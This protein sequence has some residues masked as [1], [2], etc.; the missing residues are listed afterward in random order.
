M[1]QLDLAILG[2]DQHHDTS[3]EMGTEIDHDKGGAILQK[4]RDPIPPLEAP[5]QESRGKLFDLSSQL[6]I[7]DRLVFKHD[8]RARWV[9]SGMLEQCF[10]NRVHQVTSL[11]T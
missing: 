9:L 5:R 2:I 8:G 4:Q 7:A 6:P 10:R 1:R 11:S 3:G